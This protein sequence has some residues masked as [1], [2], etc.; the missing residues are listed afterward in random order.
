MVA[1][2]CGAEVLVYATAPD[3]SLYWRICTPKA[4]SATAAVVVTG[5][6]RSSGSTCP[7][8]SPS[9]ASSEATSAIVLGAAPNIGP[10]CPLARKWW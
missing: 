6:T 4:D 7:G 5:R 1:G 10:N 8:L 3:A 9:D 2:T